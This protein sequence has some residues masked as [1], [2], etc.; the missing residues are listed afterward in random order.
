M[1][2][3]ASEGKYFYLEDAVA[4]NSDQDGVVRE[5]IGDHDDCLSHLWDIGREYCAFVWSV[6]R[7]GKNLGSSFSM[8][9]TP[10]QERSGTG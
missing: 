8:A 10:L 4:K 3:S 7:G 6:R 1:R 2:L 9:S 5:R